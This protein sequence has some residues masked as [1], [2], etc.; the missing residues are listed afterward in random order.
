[1]EQKDLKIESLIIEKLSSEPS[2]KIH[3]LPSQMERIKE[4]KIQQ[5]VDLRRKIDAKQIQMDNAEEELLSLLDTD[6]LEI[7]LEVTKTIIEFIK[8]AGYCPRLIDSILS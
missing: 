6:S 1:M 2:F 5:I 8:H 7:G 3:I 4:D